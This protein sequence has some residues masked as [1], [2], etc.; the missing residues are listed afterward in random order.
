MI[1]GFDYWKTLSHHKKSLMPL[2]QA[3]VLAGHKVYVISACGLD[4]K[5]STPK[6]IREMNLPAEVLIEMC[7]WEN[8]LDAPKLKY[9][10]CKELGVNLFFDDRQDICKYLSERGISCFQSPFYKYFEEIK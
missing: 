5:E 2:I 9:E 1:Y 7:Y 10:K 4:R 8:Q 3:L 6:K